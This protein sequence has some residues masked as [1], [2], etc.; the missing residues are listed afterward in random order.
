MAYAG[1]AG[2]LLA[3]SLLAGCNV[4]PGI[5]DVRLDEDAG[6][7]MPDASLDAGVDPGGD[8]AGGGTCEK[9]GEACWD[10]TA[11]KCCTEFSACQS[12]P[13]CAQ[14]LA[15]YND[16]IEAPPDGGE[17]CAQRLAGQNAKFLAWTNCTLLEK[18]FAAC[19]DWPLGNLCKPYCASMAE[20]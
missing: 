16:C 17:S 3:A 11:S 10:C 7:A 6:A 4:V 1:H 14:T 2:R 15:S 9:T 5:D 19:A 8:D 13:S 20:N 18:C 12:D